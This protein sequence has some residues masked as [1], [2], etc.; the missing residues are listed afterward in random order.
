MSLFPCPSSERRYLLQL[1]QQVS[2]ASLGRFMTHCHRVIAE[3]LYQGEVV[4]Q[5]TA[6]WYCDALALNRQPIDPQLLSAYPVCIAW[7]RTILEQP[8]LQTTEVLHKAHQS[9]TLDL[10]VSILTRLCQMPEE[11]PLISN[12]TLSS[13]LSVEAL[14]FPALAGTVLRS[15]GISSLP[16]L[17]A[18]FSTHSR[19]L[20]SYHQAVI[21]PLAPAT[22]K[23]DLVALQAPT[24]S[25]AA[26]DRLWLRHGWKLAE[27]AGV[28]LLAERDGSA[29]ATFAS[30]HIQQLQAWLQ[31]HHYSSTHTPYLNGYPLPAELDYA[32]LQQHW[33]HGHQGHRFVVE[34]LIN[35]LHWQ[36]PPVS[37]CGW[38]GASLP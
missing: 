16:A 17:T 26:R 3:Q 25:L 10:P 11:W 36:H 30:A 6:D 15:S 2:T 32:T 1:W 22:G 24:S 34:L 31:D 27:P 38:Q 13:L 5:V 37:A 12:A 29:L 19:P 23:A 4:S 8:S 28:N 20:P 21:T 18:L 35:H 33:Q 14:S 7:L 9:H